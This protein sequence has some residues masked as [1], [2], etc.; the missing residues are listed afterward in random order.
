M[1]KAWSLIAE[2]YLPADL[3]SKELLQQM[4]SEIRNSDFLLIHTGWSQYWG[5]EEYFM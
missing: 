5:T 1:E 4:E 3:I 2:T